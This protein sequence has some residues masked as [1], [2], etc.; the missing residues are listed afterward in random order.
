MRLSR[1]VRGGFTLVE[2]MLSVLLLSIIMTIIY[3]IVVST[4]EAAARV[5][6]ISQAGEVG[7]AILGQLRED[8]ESA[9]LLP[10]EGEQ[11]VSISRKGSTGDRDRIDFISCRTAYG[12]RRDG[13][14]PAFH[15]VNEVGYQVQESKADAS[16]GILYRRQDYFIDNEPL[17][18]GQLTEIYDRVRHFHLEFYNG[19]RWVPDWNSAREKNT[20]PAAVRIEL[21]IVVTDREKPVEQSFVHIVTF[22]R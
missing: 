10:K 14:E 9:F 19:E 4:V 17:R 5:E 2:I 3:G 16:V 1:A 18:G 11:F 13:E 8:L 20:L 21:K 12:A 7:P 22:A 15:S 6:E